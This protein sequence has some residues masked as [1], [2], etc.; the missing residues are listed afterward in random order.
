MDIYQ[1]RVPIILIII[2]VGILI[3]QY[4]TSEQNIGKL[5]DFETCELYI[6]D[7]QIS[8]KQYLNEYDSKCLEMKKL[9]S[10]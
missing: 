4:V 2:L 9:A 5:I 8:I 6:K 1:R 7:S 10:P 3:L